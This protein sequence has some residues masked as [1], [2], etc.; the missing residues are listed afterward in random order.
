M[1]GCECCICGCQQ[2]DIID[3]NNSSLSRHTCG[4]VYEDCFSVIQNAISFLM[5]GKNIAKIQTM[6]I[7]AM[8][9]DLVVPSNGS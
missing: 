1:C 3:L 7:I 4:C 8:Q 5:S 6:Q 2:V 9:N